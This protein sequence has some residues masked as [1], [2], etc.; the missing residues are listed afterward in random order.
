MTLQE[1]YALTVEIE[2]SIDARPLTY[3]PSEHGEPLPLTQAMLLHGR[4]ITDLPHVQVEQ[5]EI[6]NPDYESHS[7]LN[8]RSRYMDSLFHLSH[9]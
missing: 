9:G 6:T 2:A 7:R 1:I 3:T 5:V 8:G 4:P